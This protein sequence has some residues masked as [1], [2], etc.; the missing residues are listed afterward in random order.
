VLALSGVD[1]LEQLH[2]TQLLVLLSLQPLIALELP[3]PE[4]VL[5]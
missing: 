3:L 4:Y 5:V 1:P 2:Q